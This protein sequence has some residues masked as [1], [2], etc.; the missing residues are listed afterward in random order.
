[1]MTKNVICQE[2]GRTCVDVWKDVGAALDEAV[3]DV[4]VAVPMK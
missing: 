2:Q 4:V 3:D 1:M